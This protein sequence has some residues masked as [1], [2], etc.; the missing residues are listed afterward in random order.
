MTIDSKRPNA[1]FLYL[2]RID[3]SFDGGVQKKIK[4]Q[5]E[6]LKHNG[7]AEVYSIIGDPADN[8]IIGDETIS[9]N[10]RLR[11]LRKEREFAL[12]VTR[13]IRDNN[14]S[15]IYCR[16]NYANDII[17]GLIFQNLEKTGIKRVMEIPTY[18]YMGEVRGFPI[19]KIQDM[20]CG[21]W[22]GMNLDKI[23]TFSK[24]KRIFNCPTI[25]ISNGIDLHR[26]P[27]SARTPHNEFNFLAVSH[28]N[29]RHGLDRFINGLA[30]YYRIHNDAK[31][32]LL[33]ASADDNDTIIN[34]KR[35]VEKLGLSHNVH[36]LGF[37]GGKDLDRLFD[38]CDMAVGSLARHR[39]G[40]S[41][42]RTLKNTEYAARGVAFTYSESNPDFDNQP[43]VIRV[44]ADETP[45][46][47]ERLIKFKQDLDISP[48]EIRASVQNLSWDNQMARVLRSLS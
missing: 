25:E 14:I 18:P 4:A 12:K 32:N 8:Y 28:F 37:V 21:F 7:F 10:M 20:V 6:A 33:I 9:K 39:E 47:I 44:P 30:A 16:Y 36:F 41:T 48:D 15:F 3:F 45:I 43:Y 22:I 17:T 38:I 23:V 1:L 24:T 13:F 31:V 35:Q 11:E 40:I 26:I 27:V 46:D 5:I 19:S 34:A 2:G 42:L 29:A